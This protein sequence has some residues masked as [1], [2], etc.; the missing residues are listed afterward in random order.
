MKTALYTSITLTK[1]HATKKCD[2]YLLR[3]QYIRNDSHAQLKIPR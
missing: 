3:I 2:R 1:E